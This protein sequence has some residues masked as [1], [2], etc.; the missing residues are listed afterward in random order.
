MLLVCD[1]YIGHRYIGRMVHRIVVAVP[2]RV[3]FD[4]RQDTYD[5]HN[6]RKEGRR[7]NEP[8]PPQVRYGNMARKYGVVIHDYF[9]RHPT[10]PHPTP[11]HAASTTTRRRQGQPAKA[12]PIESK[13]DAQR[14]HASSYHRIIMYASP[15]AYP[16]GCH[17]GHVV[18]RHPKEK[19]EV[20][21]E[22]EVES[23]PEGYQKVYSTS[24]A[25]AQSV[26]PGHHAMPCHA[27]PRRAAPR[28]SAERRQG[29]RY[30]ERGA[31]RGK[32][33]DRVR[34]IVTPTSLSHP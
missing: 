23:I 4:G 9:R 28:D 14:A 13:T 20:E 6:K 1:T 27:M 33:E 12:T 24:V 2:K 3:S 26:R 29:G 32:G 17:G 10:P 30:G 11:P 5:T 7:P 25:P 19:V 16:G 18:W 21:V 22:V 34:M 8:H 15:K 31:G